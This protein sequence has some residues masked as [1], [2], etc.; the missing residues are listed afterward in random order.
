MC[1][2]FH[3]YYPS[4]PDYNLRLF[5]GR[6]GHREKGLFLKSL[7]VQGSVFCVLISLLF[8]FIIQ[9]VI[10][11]VCRDYIHIMRH[12][13]AIKENK[14]WKQIATWMIYQ[15]MHYAQKV[16]EIR[17]KRLHDSSDM[18]CHPSGKYKAR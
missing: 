15:Q 5:L 18:E 4:N 9:N 7:K 3:K 8:V 1:Q 17:L 12:Y 6:L 11:F 2:V 14:L 13:S 10:S 16:K